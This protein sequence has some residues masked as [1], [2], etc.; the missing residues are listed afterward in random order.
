MD[1]ERLT[2]EMARAMCAQHRAYYPQ[3]KWCVCDYAPGEVCNADAGYIEGYIT[4]A[5]AAITRLTDL[6]YAEWYAFGLDAMRG[7][8]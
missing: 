7:K 4:A 3:D 8:A 5:R 6:G 1:M 2:E